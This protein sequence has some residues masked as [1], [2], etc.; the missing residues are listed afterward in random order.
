VAVTPRPALPRPRGLRRALKPSRGAGIGPLGTERLPRD[1]PKE[2]FDLH[3]FLVSIL[4]QHH[5]VESFLMNR[6][7]TLLK[8]LVL[9]LDDRPAHGALPLF[10][11]LDA[12]L[13]GDIEEQQ[14]GGHLVL[15]CQVDQLFP[16]LR[17]Q[18]RGID[19][20]KPVQRKPL[21][22]KEVHQRKGLQV[23]ALVALIICDAGARPIRRNN[24]SGAKVPFGER[25]FPATR[26]AAKYDD[27]WPDEAK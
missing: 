14:G 5:L 13:E 2:D 1:R 11:T 27:R 9:T 26:R 17:R 22:Y 8:G 25:G 23:V 6:L 12:G 16:V 10:V 21:F 24:L 15:F 4:D 3:R 20:A 7:F 18:R 19:H